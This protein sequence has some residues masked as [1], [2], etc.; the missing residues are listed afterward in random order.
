MEMKLLA[1]ASFTLALAAGLSCDLADP[2]AILGCQ[3][4]IDGT[5]DF[6]ITGIYLDSLESLTATQVAEVVAA[7]AQGNCPVEFTLNVGIYNPNDG[8]G[9]SSVIPVQLSTF[10][11]DLYLDT[12]SGLNFDTTWVASGSLGQPFEVPSGGEDIVLPLDISFD[13]FTLLEE[14]GPLAFIDL[15]LAVGGIDSGI[16]DAEHLGRVLV[17]A[18]PTLSTPVGDYTYEGSLYINLDWVE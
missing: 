2:L 13:A 3:F 9:G 5:E 14:L 10:V 4:R 12:E 6:S 11:W 15:A 1:A 17:V 18:V 8:S 16:R 7:W